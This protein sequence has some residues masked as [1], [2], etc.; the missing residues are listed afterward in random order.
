MKKTKIILDCDPGYDDCVAIILAA[1][2]SNLDLI[3]I[4]TV[5]GNTSLE[6]TSKNALNIINHLNLD[7]PVCVGQAGPLV[8]PPVPAGHVHGLSGLDGLAFAPHNK[9]FHPQKSVDFIIENCLKYPKDIT[10]VT[11]GPM[12]NLAVALKYEPKIIECIS[13]IVSMGGSFGLGNVTPAAEFNIYDDPEAA[14]I[15]FNS[16][17]KVHMCGLDITSKTLVTPQIMERM[18]K[19]GNKASEMFCTCMENYNKN[20]KEAFGS[21]VGPLHDP[22]TIAYLINEKL[23]TWKRM[24]VTVDLS[25]SDSYGRTN[26]DMSLKVTNNNEDNALVGVEIDVGLFWDIVEN[27]LK[28]YS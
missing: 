28:K 12:T 13:S 8:R 16:G 4:T 17:I 15:V 6:N 5:A 24:L 3:G 14:Q 10:I 25:H 20:R 18:R 9:Q 2:A 11:T 21:D 27:E 1:K 26:C 7:V 19:I 23:I 22:V